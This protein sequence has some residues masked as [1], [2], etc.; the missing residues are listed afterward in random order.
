MSDVPGPDL[1]TSP[2][3]DQLRIVVPRYGDTVVGGAEN[4]MRRLGHALSARGWDVDV[5]TTTALDEATWN[6][7]FA[8]GLERDGDI[9]VMR[10]PVAMHR[11]RSL[12]AQLSRA[13]Y[14]LP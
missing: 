6:S 13:A 8:P 3:P 4:A 14:H 5:W 2:F 12:F 10:F 9:D 11:R 1:A 7:G